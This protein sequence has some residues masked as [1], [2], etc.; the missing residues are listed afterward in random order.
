[1]PSSRPLI[2]V[3]TAWPRCAGGASSAANGTACCAMVASTPMARLAAINTGN[4]GAAAAITQRD[5]H[6]GSLQ[7]DQAAPVEAVAERRQQQHPGRVAELRHG[8]HHADPRRAIRKRLA[9]IVE[10]RLVVIDVC[11]CHTGDRREQKQQAAQRP[12]GGS[13]SGGVGCGH[14]RGRSMDRP[15]RGPQACRSY[16]SREDRADGPT[17]APS[18]T[19]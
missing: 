8:R 6:A 9:E 14:E 11:D 15:M 1:M 2:T 13:G 5:A 18:Q 10:Q 4:V 7:Q 19:K 17:C 12:V 3:P 16:R